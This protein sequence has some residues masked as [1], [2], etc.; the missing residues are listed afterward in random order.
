VPHAVELQPPPDTVNLAALAL[1]A[2]SDGVLLIDEAGT[3]ALANQRANAMFGYRPGEL[4]GGDLAALIPEE[5]RAHHRLFEQRYRDAP[6]ARP[7]GTGLKIHAVRRDGTR[8]PAEVSLGPVSAS[9][10]HPHFV[11]VSVRDVSDQAVADE[12]AAAALL[13]LEVEAERCIAAATRM[14]TRAQYDSDEYHRALAHYTQ[15]VRHRVANP[16]HVIQGMAT[17]LRAMPELDAATRDT[18]L[19]AIHEAAMR[20]GRETI[21]HPAVQASAERELDP[22]PFHS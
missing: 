21:F 1:D 7:M 8:F 17:T 10:L 13:E 18:M 16:L 2:S 15:L 6:R 9:S 22:R 19:V 3:I 12:A 20:L 4:T 5:V 14:M 11:A